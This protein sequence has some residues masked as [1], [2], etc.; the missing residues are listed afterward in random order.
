MR[1]D[2]YSSEQFAGVQDYEIKFEPGMNVVLGN[3][4]TGKST[5]IAAI[6]YALTQT[7]K[8][9]KRKDSSFIEH[10][11]PTR[12]AKTIDVSV[13]FTQD[14]ESYELTKLWDITG[15]DTSFKLRRVGGDTL[16]GTQAEDELRALIK[17]GL[18]VYSNLIFGRQNHEE[19]ILQWCYS[20][21]SRKSDENI[22]I[23]RKQIGSAVSA[24]SG[25][26]PEKIIEE[27]DR[28]LK[29]L[30]D[31]WDFERNAPERKAGIGKRWEK[32]LGDIVKAWYNFEDA[33]IAYQNARDAENRIA[34]TTR[35]LEAA[36]SEQADIKDRKAK[37]LEQKGAIDNIANLQ[38]LKHQSERALDKAKRVLLDWPIQEDRVAEGERLLA[39]QEERA[40]K[41]KK[42]DL[43]KR[44]SKIKKLNKEIAELQ[45]DT[46]SWSDF[47]R[48][49]EEAIDLENDI[50]L[51]RATLRAATLHATIKM[52]GNYKA[53][54]DL[55]GKIQSVKN[56]DCNVSGYFSMMIPGIAEV[57]V[58]PP[59]I[60]V[61]GLQQRIENA[62]QRIDEILDEYRVADLSILGDISEEY[63]EDIEQLNKKNNEL[64]NLLDSKT[65]EEYSGMLAEIND[66]PSVYIPNNL[67]DLIE[68]YLKGNRVLDV[69][70]S[71]AKCAINGYQSEYSTIDNLKEN[72][73]HLE[74]SIENQKERIATLTLQS[75]ISK[76]QF[77]VMLEECNKELHDLELQIGEYQTMLGQLGEPSNI[78]DFQ[79]ERE[80]LKD[81]WESLKQIYCNYEKIKEDFLTYQQQDDHRFDEFHAKFNEYLAT[82]SE[83]SLTMEDNNGLLITSG[84]N[85]ISKDILS[86]GTK[87]TVLL[88]FRLAVLSY[89]FPNGDGLIVLDDDLLDM[90][91][92]RRLQAMALLKSFSEKNQIIFT[93]CDPAIAELLGGN[94]I[95]I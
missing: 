60:D 48:D 17:F 83:N 68:S 15:Q 57:L 93:T 64:E 47:K 21:F 34:S 40:R 45:Q 90:D 55:G 23:V 11:F 26:S 12:G 67:D 46:S 56:L 30:G 51:D 79:S 3:N 80:R 29:K 22:D 62:Q 16:R 7:T 86:T 2:H 4:E 5:M 91:P 9:D 52:E 65:L 63:K 27:I 54:I 37:L 24:A 77:D 32:G 70:I 59:E 76:E 35:K 13:R 74:F 73:D 71:L 25:I 88:A 61:K 53:Q 75:G 87:K 20:F 14:G 31:R 18:S 94:Q 78:A 72:I 49:F 33:D 19:E 58:E 95:K 69:A 50:A 81:E 43:K 38:E 84:K 1:I 44:I 85:P 6:F 89:Y 66:D 92:G 42:S 28:R 8:L 41:E 36:K 10:Y 39:L 82:I